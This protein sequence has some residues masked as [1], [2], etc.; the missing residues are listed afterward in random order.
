MT[1]EKNMCP[2]MIK[3]SDILLIIKTTE[4]MKIHL[5]ALPRW[6]DMN[7]TWANVSDFTDIL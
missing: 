3:W 7:I 1:P 6:Q 4:L 2:K 5:K